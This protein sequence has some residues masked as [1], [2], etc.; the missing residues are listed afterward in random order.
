LMTW[1]TLRS[2]ELQTRRLESIEANRRDDTLGP[3]VRPVSPSIRFVPRGTALESAIQPNA[4]PALGTRSFEHLLPEAPGARPDEI[5][6]DSGS[7]DHGTAAAAALPPPVEIKP[8]PAP[9]SDNASGT[10]GTAARHPA[11]PAPSHSPFNFLFR[12]QN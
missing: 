6:P 5:R 3:V 9:R 8:I 4:A 10:A 11:P 1:L 7:A 2:A 12:S